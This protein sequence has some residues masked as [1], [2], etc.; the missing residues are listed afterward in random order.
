MNLARVAS[1]FSL[2]WHFLLTPASFSDLDLLF[3]GW[4]EG[5]AAFG[6]TILP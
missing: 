5:Q 1:C 4:V 2:T 3:L 6:V